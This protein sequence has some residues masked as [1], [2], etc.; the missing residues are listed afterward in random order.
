MVDNE[1]SSDT[2]VREVF[3]PGPV[4]YSSILV[5]SME[6]NVDIIRSA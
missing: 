1:G 6:L 4:S 3:I 2:E 5:G